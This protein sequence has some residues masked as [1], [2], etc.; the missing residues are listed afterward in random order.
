VRFIDAFVD[1][2][3]LAAAGFSRVE[4]KARQV[5][6]VAPL[7]ASSGSGSLIERLDLHLRIYQREYI[8][9]GGLFLTCGFRLKN[10]LFKRPI[11][12]LTRFLSAKL[13]FGFSAFTIERRS[14]VSRKKSLVP[15]RTRSAAPRSKNATRCKI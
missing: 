8:E 12:L 4:P 9:L 5:A 3:D 13:P 15:R 11:K 6:L 14:A 1:G 2:L 10:N 7:R